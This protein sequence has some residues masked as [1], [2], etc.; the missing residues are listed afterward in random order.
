MLKRY[1]S[2]Y[3]RF[4]KAI[5][6]NFTCFLKLYLMLVNA[7]RGFIATI[8]ITYVAHTIF[9]LKVLSNKYLFDE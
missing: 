2:R 7:R 6:I 3:I 8:L 5:N 4:K 1:Y 9:Q